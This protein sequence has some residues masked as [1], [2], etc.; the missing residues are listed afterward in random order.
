[1]IHSNPLHR[2]AA[3]EIS[4]YLQQHLAAVAIAKPDEINVTSAIVS[5]MTPPSSVASSFQ[6]PGNFTQPGSTVST[7]AHARV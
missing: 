7:S 4:A 2:P 5:D 1:M 6:S 3:S